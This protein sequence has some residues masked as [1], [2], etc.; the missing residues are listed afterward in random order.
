MLPKT[1]FYDF[2]MSKLYLWSVCSGL[3]SNL[4]HL[5]WSTRIMCRVELPFYYVAYVLLCTLTRNNNN[6]FREAQ[7]TSGRFAWNILNHQT[8][9]RPSV[10]NVYSHSAERLNTIIHDIVLLAIALQ[11]NLFIRQCMRTLRKSL[12][13]LCV[14][15]N[16]NKMA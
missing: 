2:K 7:R 3:Q 15:N 4:L 13:T 6:R 9:E 8:F 16:L 11:F 14:K 1:V 12:W 5:I 10:G